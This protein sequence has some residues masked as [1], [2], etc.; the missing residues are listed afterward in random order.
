MSVSVIKNF[1]DNVINKLKTIS[2]LQY[3]IQYQE[4]E[5]NQED[6]SLYSYPAALV[7]V[8]IV[9]VVQMVKRSD[10]YCNLNIHLLVKE[11]NHSMYDGIELTNKIYDALQIQTFSQSCSPLYYVNYTI[12]KKPENFSQTILQFSTIITYQS[13]NNPYAGLTTSITAI[14]GTFSYQS[15]TESRGIYITQSNN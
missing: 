5:K 7:E 13:I 8:D 4:Q 1:Y 11:M 9:N 2:D 10:Y 12:D 6:T 15:A 14:I 3:V